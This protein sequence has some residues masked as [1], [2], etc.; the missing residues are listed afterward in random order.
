[1][2]KIS[3]LPHVTYDQED[4]ESDQTIVKEGKQRVLELRM[5]GY[6]QVLRPEWSKYT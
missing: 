1:M 5:Q 3:T 2:K 4:E 6:H